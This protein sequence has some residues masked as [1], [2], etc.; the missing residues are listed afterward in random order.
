MEIPT[1]YVLVPDDTSPFGIEYAKRFFVRQTRPAAGV[2]SVETGQHRPGF[3]LNV[4]AEWCEI[5]GKFK[6][7]IYAEP[8]HSHVRAVAAYMTKAERAATA[9]EGI[10][11][12]T[13]NLGH[14]SDWL[15]ASRF[16]APL[17]AAATLQEQIAP[18]Y[19]PPSAPG[20]ET[21]YQTARRWL[22]ELYKENERL[23]GIKPEHK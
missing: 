16:E 22:D 1:Y 17:I 13:G 7:H 8:I 23:R 6:G 9:E 21:A 18:G 15:I 20:Q 19:V 12:A 3:H 2:W 10:N 14:A 4:I 5:A 11:R